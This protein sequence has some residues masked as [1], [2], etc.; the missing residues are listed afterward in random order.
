VLILYLLK[1]ILV[2]LT[3]SISL[4]P[5]AI[6]IIQRTLNKGHLRG[7]VSGLGAAVADTFYAVLAGFG[8]SA[9]IIYIEEYQLYLRIIG[10]VILIFMGIFLIRNNIGKRLWNL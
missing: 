7:F 8:V 3:A 1:G 9:L 2:G 10:S 6:L 5:V 4:G